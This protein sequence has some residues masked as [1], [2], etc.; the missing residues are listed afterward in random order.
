MEI[1]GVANDSQTFKGL[2]HCVSTYATSLDVILTSR[3][4]Q[5]ACHRVHFNL[6]NGASF[7]VSHGGYTPVGHRQIPLFCHEIL[8][9][10]G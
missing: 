5:T 10:V 2:L 9:Q 6:Q 4:V 7:A 8:L 1:S 3:E